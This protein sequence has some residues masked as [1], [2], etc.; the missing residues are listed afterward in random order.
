MVIS[1][2]S[3]TF[4]N[5]SAAETSSKMESSFVKN[6]FKNSVFCQKAQIVVQVFL[7]IRFCSNFTSMWFK[8]VL[9][10]VGSDFRF[11]MLT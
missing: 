3:L 1:I 7:T 9:N 11:P 10:D 2:Y 4:N 8:L 5:L 6:S